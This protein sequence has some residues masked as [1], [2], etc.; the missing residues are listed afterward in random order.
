M[1]RGHLPCTP[2]SRLSREGQ[3][4]YLTFFWEQSVT[5]TC[6]VAGGRWRFGPGLVWSWREEGLWADDARLPVI[7]AQKHCLL[8]RP[9]GSAVSG[10]QCT[11]GSTQFHKVCGPKISTESWRLG[12]ERH[13][14]RN[15]LL[16]LNSCAVLRLVYKQEK[17]SC[18][19]PY[20]HLGILLTSFLKSKFPVF[21][22]F[23]FLTKM[24]YR[25]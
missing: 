11:L 13:L 10:P 22:F 4:L 16:C 7:S 1:S 12:R 3:A 24:H 19:K 6:K 20:I 21:F 18:R 25:K 15:L 2:A 17:E 8:V 5:E 9:G 23:F 14:T